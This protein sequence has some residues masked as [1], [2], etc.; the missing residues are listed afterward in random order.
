[1]KEALKTIARKVTLE[2]IYDAVDERTKEIKDELK[3]IHARIDALNARIEQQYE[4][5]NSRIEQQYT[6]LN[7]RI[8]QLFSLFLRERK[9]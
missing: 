3:T 4:A 2:I 8:D 1:M 9:Q 5:L 6:A 7:A